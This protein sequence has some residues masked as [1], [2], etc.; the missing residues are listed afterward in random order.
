MCVMT[1]KKH[2]WLTLKRQN[3]DMVKRLRLTESNTHQ[4]GKGS[5]V[6]IYPDFSQTIK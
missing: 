3:K 6:Y 2:F 4:T 5:S 1:E